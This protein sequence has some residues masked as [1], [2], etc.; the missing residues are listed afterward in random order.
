[1]KKISIFFF[2]LMVSLSVAAQDAYVHP[3]AKHKQEAAMHTFKK[4]RA[5]V[6]DIALMSQYDVHNYHLNIS[7]ENN[8]L[9]VAGSTLIGAKVIATSIDTFAFELHSAH[10]IDSVKYNGAIIP[11]WHVADM[12]Y[13]KFPTPIAANANF[14][15]IV[16]Y[17]GTCPQT[18][19]SAIGYGYNTDVS[20]S[21]G[22]SVTW[23]LSQPYSAYHWFACKQFLQD[24]ADSS[25]V[26]ITTSNFNKAG[27][28]GVLV[29]IDSLPNNKLRY[30]WK[31]NLPINYYLISVAVAKYV[32]YTTYAHPT[33]FPNDSIKIQN[34]IYDNPATL[35]KYKGN[36]DTM[37]MIMEYFSEKISLYPFAKE[38][39]GHCMAPFSGGMEHQTMTSQGV[40]E[41][42]INAHEMFHQWFGD[43]VTC[44]TWSDIFVN[45]GF[46]S[47]GEYLALEKW[48]SYTEAQK[49]MA[50][51]H[52]RVKQQLGGSIYTSDT[53]NNRIFDSRLSYDKGSA[54]IHSLRFVLGDSLFFKTL[55]I[56]QNQYANGNATIDDFKTVAETISGKNLTDFF[57]QWIYG[58]GYPMFTTEYTSSGNAIILKINHVGSMAS[59]NLY[60][61]PLEVKCFSGSGDT[62]LLLNISANTNTFYIPSTK[63]ITNIQLDPNNWILDSSKVTKNP[64]LLLS[65][66]NTNFENFITIYPNPTNNIFYCEGAKYVKQFSITDVVGRMVKNGTVM[67]NKIDASNWVDGIYT[68]R[69]IDVFGQHHV[70]KLVKK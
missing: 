54:V 46:A 44:K 31:S 4:T 8:S 64:D 19:S 34:Y 51:V 36:L 38:K 37:A 68:I 10:T 42:T 1:M 12:G 9:D 2:S 57:N 27:S 21:W 23:S 62:T 53:S 52:R 56:Y 25:S 49:D 60:K 58:E 70:V 66:N 24:K 67:E 43:N 5:A 63:N 69:M 3:C 50:N 61:T 11:S 26:S 29:S 41:F 18:G 33:N 47:Y 55:T 28:N 30:N 15:I 13:A 32:E 39:Y 6:N 40:F 59:N 65:I 20:P 22:N 17:H 14:D 16:Y 7:T 48:R 45:E 35:T